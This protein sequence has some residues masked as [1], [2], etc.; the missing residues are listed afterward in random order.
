MMK[1]SK[2]ER[3][4]AEQVS[5]A[6]DRWNSEPVDPDDA[7]LLATAERLA[8]LPSLLGPVDPAL[9]QQVMRHVRAGGWEARQRSGLRPG[10]AA[11]GL[12]AVL[13]VVL[14][15]TPLGETA[16]AGFMAVFNLGRTEVS[17]TPVGADLTAMAG[18]SSA[19]MATMVPQSTAVQQS[20]TLEQAQAQL[21]FGL[22]QPAY[23]PPG[24][25]L[26]RVNS[27]SYPELPAWVPQPLFAELVYSD[28]PGTEFSLHVYPIVLGEQASISGLNLQASPIQNVQN[29]DLNGQPGVLLQLGP[30]RGR[31]TWQEVV[32]ERGDLM[33]ALSSSDLSEADLMRIARSVP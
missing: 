16:L 28:G 33:L 8:R 32:W 6:V 19:A 12:A 7:A 9:E 21:P 11:A 24:T 2:S 20:L 30:E 25:L 29:V 14:L 18:T 5:A 4:R 1:A 27:Y 23:L 3:M 31:A 13:L 26:R 15:L 10:W 22:P 17:I